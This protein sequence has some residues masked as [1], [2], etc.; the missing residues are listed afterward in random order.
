MPNIY[1]FFT[2]ILL[3]QLA[4][5]Q[6]Q[7]QIIDSEYDLP[8]TDAKIYN[9][10]KV[11]LTQTDQEGK[12]LIEGHHRFIILVS[13]G[14]KDKYIQLNPSQ[15]ILYLEFQQQLSEVEVRAN[16]DESR[17]L[18]REVMR[19]QKKNH[20]DNLDSY[21]F[22]SYQKINADTNPDSIKVDYKKMEET[23]DSSDFFNKKL[24]SRTSLFLWEKVL[25]IKHHKKY[26]NKEEVMAQKMSGLKNPIYELLAFR[27]ISYYLE[28]EEFNFFMDRYTNPV[29]HFGLQEFKYTIVDTMDIGSKKV[30]DVRY[31]PKYPKSN[32]RPIVGYIHIDQESKSIVEFYAERNKAPFA[33]IMMKWKEHSGYYFPDSQY[34]YI[35]INDRDEGTVRLESDNEAPVW[36]E[37]RST[38]KNF[39]IP[40]ELEAKEFRGYDYEINP[41]IKKKSEEILTQDRDVLSQREEETYEVMDSIFSAHKVEKYI[42][43]H[44]LITRGT[45]PIGNKIE[46]NIPKLF[47]LND[48]EGFRTQLSFNTN[49]N[50][51]K[52]WRLN[53]YG[54]YGFKDKEF[55]FGGGVNYLVLPSNSGNLFL[56]FRSD[57]FQIGRYKGEFVYER[58]LFK[59]MLNNYYF[60]DYYKSNRWKFG[61][62]QDFFQNLT[63]LIYGEWAEDQ[64][65][66]PYSYN[67][68][69]LDQKYNMRLGH[70]TMLWMPFNK[71]MKTPYGKVTMEY[72]E[73][74]IGMHLMKSFGA[75]GS[76]FDFESLEF[77]FNHDIQ[78][79]FGSLGL[80]ARGGYL[81]GNAPLFYHFEGRG[82]SRDKTG[83][84]SKDLRVAGHYL[85]ETMNVSEF[86][87]DRF[88]NFQLTQKLPHM[89]LRKSKIETH[90]I[91]RGIWGDQ[92]QTQ[93][94][95]IPLRAPI[96]YYQ[97]VG[98]EIRK[99]LFGMLGVGGYYRLG[100]YANGNFDDDFFFKINFNVFIP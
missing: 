50:F 3:S 41:D 64:A 93:H 67:F 59:E 13:E 21:S 73:S 82:N 85:F 28:E 51:D 8:V 40:S 56:D 35:Q 37:Q 44:H 27:P 99:M 15:S 89:Q 30:I 34:Y 78:F 68:N 7:Y 4:F 39:E 83:S 38:F 74:L 48:Y 77:W 19:R 88:I 61:Y 9:T 46:L 58:T 80:F 47:H 79:R 42:K 22:I 84:F 90:L 71:Y 26:G 23:K 54:A 11:L 62:E 2:I 36:L 57:V 86:Y 65:A 52:R 43:Y 49:E 20:P 95:L 45:L 81:W 29:S 55:K 18:I 87:M 6:M 75:L 33:Y 66:V 98:I 92:D 70:F 12:F 72:G 53:A 14:Y 96:D 31:S 24:M 1:L 63:T 91:Y 97:E 100:N 16:N 10:D 76:D 32:K 94:V 60:R 5:A 17:D 69:P 25:K